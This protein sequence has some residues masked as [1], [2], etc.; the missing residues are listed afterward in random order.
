MKTVYLALGLLLLPGMSWAQEPQKENE[1]TMSMQIRPRAEYRNGA[2]FPRSE[3]DEAASFINNRARLFMEY[4]RSDLSMKISAQHV[5]VWGQ[6][7]LL[8]GL[9]W[10]VA[11][12]YHDAMKLGYANKAHQLHL[13]LAFN[14]NKEKTKGGMYYYDGAQPYKNMQTLW[15][16]YRAQTSNFDISLLFL[17]LGLE[18][19]DAATET[20]H[21]RYLQTFGT[22]LTYKPK[23]WDMQGSFYYQTGK[24]KAAQSV[25]AFISML[26][27]GWDR[28]P[29]C[30]MPS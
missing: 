21:T 4:K 30:R 22:Y 10:N 14:Q 13:I 24:N 17:N 18:T 12:R 15:Y 28:L 26:L 8:G 7:P 3:G 5:G 23:S 11:G 16:H 20:S 19:G 29:D 2:L 25:S 6:D 1:F 27:P 9:D